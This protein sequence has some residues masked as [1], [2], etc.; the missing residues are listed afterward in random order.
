MLHIAAPGGNVYRVALQREAEIDKYL[1]HGRLA[2]VRAEKGVY[3]IRLQLHGRRLKRLRHDVDN[4]VHDLARAE[5][6]HKLARA[7]HGGEGV[8]HVKTLFKA[9]G[10]VRAHTQR[11]GR[12]AHGGAVEVCA[13]KQH[14]RRVADDLAVLAAHHAR[15]AHG[16][17]GVADAQH[18]RREL[19]LRSVKRAYDL[20]LARGADVYLAVVDTGEV[21]RVHRLAVLQHDIVRD[22]DDIVYRAHTGVADTLAHPFG[23]GG[24]LYVLDH[25]RG[26][27]RTERGVLNDDLCK[28]V[29]VAAGLGLYHRLMQRQLLAEGDGGLARKA[30]H[31]QAVGAVGR[32]LKLDHVV[33]H[34]DERAYIV[35]GAAVLVQHEYAVGDAVGELLLLGVQVGK[36][37]YEPRL[38]VI[39]DHV[40]LVH[41]LAAAYRVAHAGACVKLALP[42]VDAVGLHARHL[43]RYHA[44]EDGLAAADVGGDGRRVGV[45]RVVVAKYGGGLY[46]TVGVVV[47][48]ELQLLEGAQHTVGFNAAQLA[49]GYLHAAGQHGIVQR[50]GNH[51]ALMHIPRAGAYLHG[52]LR[53][54][55]YLRH[56]HVVGI[57]VLRDGKDP[58][59]LDVLDALAQILG[60]LHLRAGDSH[61]L[62]EG[63]VVILIYRKINKLVEPF[64]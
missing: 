54:D 11:R 12:A 4:A 19:A 29:Y 27:A 60:Y 52:R 2:D 22:I 61:R 33:V 47:R 58:A 53:A 64:S 15:N 36:R 56:Q 16:L 41:V 42:L 8:L 6:F 34:A 39:G 18:V 3:L 30:D 43:C 5:H 1:A 13:F 26:V 62:A 7:L 49:A 17:V 51:V 32:D 45:E 9:G 38:G 57:R 63:A 23:A 55:V 14:H 31:A 20:A 35:A 44:A 46:L 24:D 25:A 50:R 40:A 21:E 48:G 37:A 59:H 10:R 28:L